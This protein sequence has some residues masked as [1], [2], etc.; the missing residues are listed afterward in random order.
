M[1]EDRASSSSG[2]ALA[3]GVLLMIA[4]VPLL[5]L[6][7]VLGSGG[8]MIEFESSADHLEFALMIGVPVLLFA[9]GAAL[10]VGSRSERYG[11]ALLFA[12][13]IPA[14]I[15]AEIQFMHWRNQPE[16]TH[17][18]MTSNRDALLPNA[19]TVVGRPAELAVCAI[20]NP[21]CVPA[22]IQAPA[23]TGRPSHQVVAQPI[24]VSPRSGPPAR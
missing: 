15:L 24:A 8:E 2:I 7:F 6:A 9:A 21:R 18:D 5:L 13:L 3:A 17:A 22:S 1:I 4:A 12:I 23:P 11:V 20:G 16:P 10:A 14:D 19:A